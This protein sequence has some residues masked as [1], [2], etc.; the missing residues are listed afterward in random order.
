MKYHNITKNDMLNGDGLRT[1]LW[2]SGCSHHC[3]GCQ[4]QITWDPNLGLDFSEG[5]YE[6]IHSSLSHDYVSG[7]TLSGGD[8]LYIGNLDDVLAL[9]KRVKKDFPEKTIWLYSGYV[10]EEIRDGKD[11]DMQKR[12]DILGY[13]DTFVDGKFNHN[14]RNVDLH[15]VGSSNQ[16]ILD[17]KALLSEYK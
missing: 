11:N 5:D 13:V 12:R 1:V 2:L 7:L 9:V 17:V 6:E 10:W 3:E 15:W 4:N 14:L 8:P 16:R